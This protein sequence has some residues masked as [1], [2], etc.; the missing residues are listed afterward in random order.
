M[1]SWWST[2]AWET[3]ENAETSERRP[4]R[5]S[6]SG[7][8]GTGDGS[9]ESRVEATGHKARRGGWRGRDHATVITPG[10]TSDHGGQAAAHRTARGRFL[11]LQNTVPPRLL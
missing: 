3:G 11:S 7:A 6:P 5:A 2:K 1:G 9:N 10:T 4:S 8:R